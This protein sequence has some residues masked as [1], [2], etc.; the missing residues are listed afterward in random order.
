MLPPELLLFRLNMHQNLS[1]LQTTVTIHV[2]IWSSELVV[3]ESAD[4]EA[5]FIVV[6]FL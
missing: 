6:L 3:T 1:Y 2:V 5:L 4:Q